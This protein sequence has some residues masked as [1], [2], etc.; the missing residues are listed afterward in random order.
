MKETYRG[1]DLRP[2]RKN[3]KQYCTK[4]GRVWDNTCLPPNE[5][6]KSGFWKRINNMDYTLLFQRL[7]IILKD[8]E[9]EHKC[10]IGCMITPDADLGIT[11]EEVWEWD[12]DGFD[13]REGF[14]AALKKKENDEH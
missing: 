8:W 2:T 4:C 13:K 9:K 10:I 14:V 1:H 3:D 12:G 6:C 7:S 11:G 5:D